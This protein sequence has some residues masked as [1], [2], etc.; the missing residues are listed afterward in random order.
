[1]I[2][3]IPVQLL[4]QGT[5]VFELGLGSQAWTREGRVGRGYTIPDLCSL[6]S[7]IAKLKFAMKVTLWMA[8][9]FSD[10]TH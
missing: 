6:N 2:K 3:A 9:I 10:K 8:V 7:H 5:K 1:M 4:P